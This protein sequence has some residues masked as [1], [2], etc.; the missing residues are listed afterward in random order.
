MIWL[1]AMAE[2]DLEWVLALDGRTESAPH[3]TAE[4]YRAFL[5]PDEPGNALRHFALLAEL[6]GEQA[7]VALGRLLLDGVENA[8][9]LEWIAAETAMRHRGVGKALMAGV[10]AWSRDH[11]GLRLILEVRSGNISAQRL[12]G[13]SG[14]IVM[15]R[16]R[17]YYAHP[18]EDA[19][20]MERLPGKGEKKS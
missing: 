17:A 5:Q 20:L 19:V 2:S 8:C 1:R 11:G 12:Y 18:V 10:E 9:E 14:W 4:T 16:R 6:D 15:G 7:G 13:H 3:W